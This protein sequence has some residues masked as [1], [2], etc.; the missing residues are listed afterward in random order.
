MTEAE[1]P[2][3]KNLASKGKEEIAKETGLDASNIFALFDYHPEFW[4]LHVHYR[5]KLNIPNAFLEINR[6]IA[7]VAPN[8][9]Y[10]WPEEINTHCKIPELASRL[11]KLTEEEQ[12]VH[13]RGFEKR[14]LEKLKYD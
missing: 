5:Y 2:L 9:N 10:K 8:V 6:C 3:L 7:R 4:H 14:Y 13:K 12:Q 1:I 11:K